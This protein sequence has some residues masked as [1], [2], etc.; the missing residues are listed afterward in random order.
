MYAKLFT[1]MYDGTL[2]MCGPWE[3]LVTFQQI[4]ILCDSR[5]YIDMT[6]D[7]IARRTTI[8]IDII[9]KG[10]EVLESPDPDSRT[11]DEEGRRIVRLDSHRTWGWR[12]VNHAKFRN[13]RTADERREYMKNYQKERRSKL[14]KTDVNNS[15][16]AQQNKP[17]KPILEAE[18]EAEV[19]PK[20]VSAKP[21]PYDWAEPL[22]IEEIAARIIDRHPHPVKMKQDEFVK[23]ILSKVEPNEFPEDV[24]EEIDRNH[25]NLCKLE[26][27]CGGW[28]GGNIKYKQIP[29]LRDWVYKSR[30]RVQAAPIRIVKDWVG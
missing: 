3:A 11:P 1:S 16:H 24:F 19:L 13:I 23:A 12:V 7:A 29:S 14:S 30:D 9:L 28:L 27:E 18:A 4:L 22:L 15:K 6:P 5:G 26:V 10:I 2:A 25:V 20:K 8:P 21:K 17:E